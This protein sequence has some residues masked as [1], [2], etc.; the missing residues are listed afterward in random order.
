MS[1][2]FDVDEADFEQRVLE[3]SREL[4]V[5]VDFWAAWCGPLQ[6]AHTRTRAR[7]DRTRRQGRAGQAGRRPEPAPV[8]AVPDSGDPGGQG[9]SRR[10]GGVRVHRGAAARRGGALLRRA[11]ALSGRRAPRKWRRGLLRQA[12]EL[13]P[14][15]AVARRELGRILLRRGEEEAA[16][17]LLEGAA[18][19]F[20]ADGLAA[21]AG[22][23]ATP[24]FNRPSR[25]G[26]PAIT[27]S[28]S[29]G[30]RPPSRR[31]RPTVTSCAA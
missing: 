18:G 23:P 10:A 22:W 24:S 16:L 13:D 21:R 4:P 14:A 20:L 3:R 8:D 19:D 17:E 9:V 31:G 12:L 28:R 7:G 27:P 15:N 29:S 1:S 30:C 25:R 5:V 2:I 11:G 26:T 6:A